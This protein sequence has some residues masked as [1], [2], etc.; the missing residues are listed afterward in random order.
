MRFL[1][2]NL[3]VVA[4]LGYL[5]LTNHPEPKLSPHTNA[6]LA[7]VAPEKTPQIGRA[8]V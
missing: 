6:L 1:V 2:F 4:A 3:I 8:H 7:E 5:F